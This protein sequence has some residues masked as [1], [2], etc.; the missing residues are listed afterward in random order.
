[1]KILFICSSLDMG[2]AQRV[3]SNI[4]M[5][6]P[7]N[8]E[9]HILL[10][11]SDN[12]LFPYKGTIFEL[13]I[14][15][16]GTREGIKYQGKVFILRWKKVKELKKK[17]H[18]DYVVSFLESANILNIL[19][20]TVE[21]KSILTT[22]A[23]L[24]FSIKKR[25]SYKFIVQPL[26]KILYNRAD[27]I[28]AVSEGVRQDFIQ[29]FSVKPEKIITIYNGINCKYIEQNIA[30][31]EE[32]KDCIF[33]ICT[34]GRLTEQKGQWHL[35]RALSYLRKKGYPIEL[36]IIGE[37]ELLEVFK[38]IVK[39]YNLEKNVYFEGFLSP[40]FPLISKCD[41]F[42]FPSLW[43]GFGNVIIEA[44]A[45]GIPTVSTDYESGAREILAPDTDITMKNTNEIEYAK[46]GILIPNLSGRML[47]AEEP[48]EKEEVLLA[49]AIEKMYS[50]KELYNMYRERTKALAERYSMKNIGKQW[51]DFFEKYE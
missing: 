11:S 17:Y 26:V 51:I 45:C 31:D 33:R 20:K 8:W 4:L 1:M 22:H 15:G 9:I 35:I 6:L 16:E 12:I 25:K 30:C 41:L 50:D 13:G 3:L 27:K 42:V 37:G 21:C 19:T 36:H 40:P 29:N 48:L 2:G 5:E 39:L 34:M 44:A 10:N 28:I 49:K 23:S 46:Y 47:G 43:E 7:S 24:T 32:K 14:H 18:Y 38:H